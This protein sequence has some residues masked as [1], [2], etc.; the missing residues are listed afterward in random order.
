[1]FPIAVG[2]WVQKHREGCM[3]SETVLVSTESSSPSMSI[4]HL[5]WQVQRKVICIP[6]S[7]TP[8]RIL[9]NIQVLDDGS[10]LL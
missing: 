9:Q 10:P 7:I 3:E 4:L 1:M 5:R 6:K 2:L 8:S